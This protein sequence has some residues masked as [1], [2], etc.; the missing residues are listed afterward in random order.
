MTAIAAAAGRALAALPSVR[1]VAVGGS[2]ATGTADERSDVDLYVFAP[3]DP[4]EEVRRGALL[5]FAAPGGLMIGNPWFGT[6][7]A[8]ELPSG[9][10]IDASYFG[11]GWIEDEIAARLD[12]HE[13]KLGH[14]TAIMHTLAVAR[15]LADDGWLAGVRERVA[16]PYP[17]A[18]ADAIE[19]HNLPLL[20]SAPHSLVRQIEDAGARND[21]I[22][23][24]H[25][26]AAFLA[27]ATDVLFARARHWHPGEKRLAHHLRALE[28]DPR[29]VPAIEAL[30]TAGPDNAPAHARALVA[31]LCTTERVAASA[32]Q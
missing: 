28:L 10:S 3:A 1:A 9:T 23:L 13:P 8:C 4:P 27:S 5:P 19:A 20:A 16:R 11:T 25:R 29:I 15:P 21:R 12:R 7:D 14:T 26:I 18:L 31:L 24:N 17:D 32:L 6:A 22:A 2:H 30:A